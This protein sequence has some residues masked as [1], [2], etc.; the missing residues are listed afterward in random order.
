LVLIG[1]EESHV[2]AHAPEDLHALVEAA[3]NERDIDALIALYEDD[4]T[5]VVP[6]QGE[7]VTGADA[8][9]AAVEPLMALAPRARMEVV[10]K[11][12]GGGLAVTYGRWSLAGTG[13]HEMSGRG[14][15]VSRRQPDGSWRI[16][17]DNPMAP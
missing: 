15:M 10:E 7:R 13:D 9:R 2:T 14:T 17:L 16:V 1:R 8:I 6:P 5:Q 4:A 11:V 12:E 3:F